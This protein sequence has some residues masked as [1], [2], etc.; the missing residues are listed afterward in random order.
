MRSSP[1][2]SDVI[3][4][5]QLLCGLD[6]ER[7]SLDCEGRGNLG[8]E[9]RDGGLDS[10]AIRGGM[11]LITISKYLLALFCDSASSLFTLHGS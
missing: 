3:L 11:S 6:S 9:E 7:E 1:A 8:M 4:M 2:P 10:N 5:L